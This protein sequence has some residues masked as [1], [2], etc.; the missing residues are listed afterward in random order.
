[1]FRFAI[2]SLLLSVLPAVAS[3]TPEWAVAVFPSGAEFSLEIA[4][5]DRERQ[6]GYMFREEV[7]ADKGMVFLFG[8]TDLHSIWMKNCRVPLDII[9]LDEDFRVIEIVAG[10]QPCPSDGPCPPMF[11]MRPSRYVLEIA[12]GRAA[13]EMLVRGDVVIIHSEPSL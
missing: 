9:W 10:A 7:G 6:L 11:P 12:G 8:A 4:A 1:M 13:E 2:L 3:E 5:S